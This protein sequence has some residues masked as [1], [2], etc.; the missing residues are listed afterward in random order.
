MVLDSIN[1]RLVP[2]K[3]HYFLFN[4]GTAPVVPFLPT[5]ARQL[6]FSA[7][8]VG[9]L[10]TVLPVAGMLAKPACG[11]IADRL[12]LHKSFFL[13][14]IAVTAVAFLA[15]GFIPE[16]SSPPLTS[17]HLD[18][19]TQTNLM[20]CGKYAQC[21]VSRL[22]SDTSNMTVD[23]YVYCDPSKGDKGWTE[24]CDSWN[25]TQYCYTKDI[26]STYSFEKSPLGP[27]S[28][29]T[30]KRDENKSFV[31]HLEFVAKVPIRH[32]LQVESCLYLRMSSVE[33]SSGS[34]VP[35]CNHVVREKCKISCDNQE[36]AE[37]I[38]G[39]QQEPDSGEDTDPWSPSDSYQFWLFSTLLLISWIGMAV[40][41]SIGDAICFEM[42]G[43]KPGD[44][45]RQRLWGAFGWGIFSALAGF[46]VDQWS[47]GKTQ[48]NYSPVFYLSLA[49]LLADLISSTRL[50]HS[51]KKMSASILRDI[52]R[53]FTEFRVVIFLIWC[54]A[55]GLCTGVLWQHLE[56]L[57]S[58][59]D[60]CAVTDWV[61]TLEGLVMAIQCFG[62]EIPFFFLSG[63][64]LNKLGHVNTMTL[65]LLAFGVR[66]ILYSFLVNPWYALPI[67]LLN[68]LTFG[69]AYS[70]M[71]SY[72]S[73]VAPPGTEATVQGLVG[74]TFE[75]VGVSLGSLIGGTLLTEYGG[76]ITFRAFGIGALCAF[77]LHGAVN[78]FCFRCSNSPH[79]REFQKAAGFGETTHYSSPSEAVRILNFGEGRSDSRPILMSPT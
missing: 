35:V 24:L 22:E 56:E 49:L 61:K 4:A 7:F 68:G 79:P 29:D 54:A 32:T 39:I 50:K 47:K 57:A 17:A 77:L 74:A 44:Y 10:Y 21:A 16:T 78:F 76:S 37:A 19:G 46:L 62:G 71:A 18:C 28:S 58:K 3:A 38:T 43:D 20:V 5:Y 55:I 34:H 23:C 11:A 73:I 65:V 13:A 31:N 52:G 27:P 33:F 36:V 63:K 75:G 69:L 15:T 26:S 14:A 53:L 1:K 45:G 67:E 6:G 51:E 25:I 41:V 72:A 70:T 40:T 2:M 66:M 9:T 8:A 60:T 48:K 59:M 30:D 12:R 64:I 42:L